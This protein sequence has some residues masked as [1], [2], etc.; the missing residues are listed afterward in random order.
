[1]SSTVTQPVS[2]LQNYVV[3]GAWRKA[4]GS[5][6]FEVTNPASG[7]L[8]ARTPL[9]TK[10][11]LD[12]AVQSALANLDKASRGLPQTAHDLSSLVTELR[13][14]TAQLAASAQ[15]A[16][17][18][19]DAVRPDIE[20]ATQRLH[21]VADLYRRHTY[22]WRPVQ[23]ISE[24]LGVSART[25]ARYVEKCRTDGLLPPREVSRDEQ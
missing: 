19:I 9:S 20:Q 7:Q 5:E 10:A 13:S 6:T 11:D 4:S 16:H 22:G 17:G 18:V 14:A 8:L 3:G 12:A 2:D 24:V 15:T 25:A 1:M 21:Q 23:M